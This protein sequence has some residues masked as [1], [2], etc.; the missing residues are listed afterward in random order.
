MDRNTMFEVYIRHCAYD[1]RRLMNPNTHRPTME[2]GIFE[3]DGL[4]KT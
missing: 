4:N 3:F 1:Q 2:N